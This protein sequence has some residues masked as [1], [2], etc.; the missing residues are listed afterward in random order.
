MIYFITFAL[1]LILTYKYDYR[2][3][4]SKRL[5]WVVVIWL[6]FMLTAGM[7]YRIGTDS[8]RYEAYFNQIPGLTEIGARHFNDAAYAR[9]AP[10]YILLNSVVKTFSEDFTAFQFVHSIIVCSVVVFFFYRNARNLFFALLIFYVFQY[11]NLTTEVL[12]ES[13]AVSVFLLAW[14]FFRDSKWIKW[15]LMSILALFFHVSAIMMLFIPL[16]CVPGIRQLFVF[17][18]RTIPICILF[19]ILAVAINKMFFQYIQLL[20]LADNVSERASTYSQS[21]YGT[22]SLNF[23][24]LTVKVILNMAYPLFAMFFI[25]KIH[26]ADLPY[27]YSK[28]QMLSLLGIYIVIFSLFIQ[29]MGRFNNY[30]IFFTIIIVSDFAYNLIPVLGR[31]V[32]FKFVY[33]MLFF[34]PLIGGQI[35]SSYFAGGSKG[36][37]HR[38]YMAY[39]PYASRL[40]M[41]KDQAREKFFR[42]LHAR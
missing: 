30:L 22:S 1:L 36:G 41:N 6:L 13:L 24:G 31:R 33:W 10:G 21:K 7:R 39:Y 9:F 37:T 29:I 20:E 25:N 15:Y 27:S 23:V 8:I 3:E 12:R 14:P 18:K 32:Q 11:L 2:Q 16:I 19:V 40:D 26:K 5:V 17:G 34:T 38:V 28:M 35:Y 42:Y 4:T